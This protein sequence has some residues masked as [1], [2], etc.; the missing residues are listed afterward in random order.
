MACHSSC[1]SW[2]SIEAEIAKTERTLQRYFAAFEEE[3]LSGK[4]LA[5]GVAEWEQRM[6]DL[7]ARREDSARPSMASSTPVRPKWTWATSRR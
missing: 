5:E 7:N 3:A 1:T 6:T 2:W 4:R